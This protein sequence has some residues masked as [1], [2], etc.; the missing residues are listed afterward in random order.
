MK[1]KIWCL[2]LALSLL[3]CACQANPAPDVDAPAPSVTNGGSQSSL[4]SPPPSAAPAETPAAPV[5]SQAETGEPAFTET[6]SFPMPFDGEQRV[7]G[8]G[9]I[10]FTPSEA[11]YDYDTMWLLLE[12][13]YPYFDCIEAEMGIDW[14]AVRD[15]YR[16]FMDRQ[17]RTG[18]GW[19]TQAEFIDT[20]DRCLGEFHNVG[21]L[22]PV[23]NTWRSWSDNFQASK[24]PLMRTL[25]EL[26]QNPRSVQ[27]YEAWEEMMGWDASPLP[28]GD[29]AADDGLAA[30]GITLDRIDGI[31][32]VKVPTF[33][34]W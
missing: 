20:I 5:A 19:L 18:D 10:V 22:Y 2:M 16:A 8:K 31:P 33:A 21:H 23:R 7:N 3:L 27:F 1:R 28:A 9:E 12:E 25:A 6:A 13:N 15:K 29:F 30:S 34:V 17:A 11:L 4:E 24:N 26:M 14:R 32:Y